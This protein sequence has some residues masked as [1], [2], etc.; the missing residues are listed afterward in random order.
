[1]QSKIQGDTAKSA[2]V[3]QLNRASDYGSE[4]SGFESL[5]VHSV[6]YPNLRLRLGFLF[7]T[8]RATST[9]QV[10]CMSLIP[11][12]P[13]HVYNRITIALL[14]SDDQRITK[15]LAGSELSSKR[16]LIWIQNLSKIDNQTRF[17]VDHGIGIIPVG[18]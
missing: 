6:N 11:G 12:F 2:L 16:R 4:G 9:S 8:D 13:G 7:Y 17:R 10:V 18:N 14:L 15:V 5:R 1:L 3:A